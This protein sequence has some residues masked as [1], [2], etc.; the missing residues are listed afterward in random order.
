MEEMMSYLTMK[1]LEER[2]ANELAST[3]T[4][5]NL[6][7]TTADEKIEA[8]LQ[9]YQKK[10]EEDVLFFTP[11]FILTIIKIIPHHILKL[12]DNMRQVKQNAISSD[13]TLKDHYQQKI[14]EHEIKL[15][16]HDEALQKYSK[17]ISGNVEA[18]DQAKR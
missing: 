6:V 14:S 17:F 8:K 12:E 1:N 15:Q 18:L 4:Q 10:L 2:I 7:N 5:V 3:N 16:E 13:N 9:Q 11:I